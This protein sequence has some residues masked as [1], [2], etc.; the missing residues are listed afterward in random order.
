MDV[1]L[2]LLIFISFGLVL[3]A[4]GI[5]ASRNIKTRSD[6]FLAGRDLGLASVTFTLIAIQLGGNM[7]LGAAEWAYSYGMYGLLYALGMSA[8]FLLLAGGFAAKLH[9]CNVT[10]TAELLQKRYHSSAL[11]TFAAFI[12]IVS[13]MGILVSIVVSSRTLLHGLGIHHE[14]IFIL[15]WLIIMSYIMLGGLHAVVLTDVAQVIFIVLCIGAVFLYCM[16]TTPAGLL[17]LATLVQ[18]QSLFNTQ[19]LTTGSITAA[20]LMPALFALIEQ[21]LAQPLFAARSKSIALLAAFFAGIFIIVFGSIPVY[22]GMQARL[23]N[24]PLAATANP[25][26]AITQY[27]TSPFVFALIICSIIAA[28]TSTANSLICAVSANIVQDFLPTMGNEKYMV[29]IAKMITLITGCTAIFASYYMHKTIIEI[30]IGS[31]EISVSCLLI[32]LICALYTKKPNKHG[33]LVAAVGGLIGFVAFRYHAL[34]VPKEILTLSLSAIGYIL[35]AYCCADE[36]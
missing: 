20:F 23:L 22:F 2:F 1:S 24:V 35:G 33:A 18:S 25:F 12:S 19:A 26:I 32:P 4:I 34:P 11:R 28:I 5:M 3:F 9:E 7:I 6:F 8:G 27:C 21:D 13:L 36:K 31:Y 29:R 17:P 30:A 15:F 14:Q 10:T 16:L